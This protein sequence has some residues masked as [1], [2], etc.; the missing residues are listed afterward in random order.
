MLKNTVV[1]FLM[2]A[3]KDKKSAKFH[4]NQLLS[5]YLASC[6]E[7]TILN[8]RAYKI[9]TSDVLKMFELI[10]EKFENNLLFVSF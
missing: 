8:K 7:M 9:Y 10:L 3:P 5:P 1:I 6:L 2:V 4:V